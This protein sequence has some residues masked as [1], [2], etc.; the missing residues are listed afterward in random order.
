[1]LLLQSIGKL[2]MP[3]L[4]RN[5]HGRVPMQAPQKPIMG[6]RRGAVR[7]SSEF[8]WT[9]CFVLL[10]R[11]KRASQGLDPLPVLQLLLAGKQNIVAQS[12][13]SLQP[14]TQGL[15]GTATALKEF[16]A[17]WGHSY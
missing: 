16:Q 9:S 12:T 13:G 5:L 11:S 15:S 3:Q 14:S 17:V 4:K 6:R 8:P 10:W 2:G 1:M 7:V